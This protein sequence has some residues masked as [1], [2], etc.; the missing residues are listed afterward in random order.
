MKI[1]DVNGSLEHLTGRIATIEEIKG[2]INSKVV[3]MTNHDEQSYI[4]KIYKKANVN[5]LIFIH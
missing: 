2:G 5:F 4:L 1:I 3:K